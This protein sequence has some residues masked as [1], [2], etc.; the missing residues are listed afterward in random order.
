MPA[1][2]RTTLM[3]ILVTAGR[4]LTAAQLIALA[5]P[6]GISATNVK[7][8]LSRMVSEGVLQRKG[9][10][11]QAVYGP[12]RGQSYIVES[13]RQRMQPKA[14][15]RWDSTWLMLTLPLPKNRS[16]RDHLRASLWFDGFRALD[17][18]VFVRP[19]WPLPW[20]EEQ[21]RQYAAAAA[22]TCLRG[23]MVASPADFAR[24]YDLDGLDSDARILAARIRRRKVSS[25]SPRK[26]FAERMRVGGEAVQLMAHDPRLPKAVW[27]RRRGMRQLA[28]AF[29]DFEQRIGKRAASFVEEAISGPSPT[30]RR[31]S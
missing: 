31:K 12:G 16:Q 20:A 18:N 8:H 26:A 4:Q 14:E 2:S 29:T 21:A 10:A 5:E 19:A 3:G 13:I 27:G 25:M 1:A 11:R 15:A 24:L 22:G 9:P 17:S 28:Q 7:S 6:L 30:P 23:G